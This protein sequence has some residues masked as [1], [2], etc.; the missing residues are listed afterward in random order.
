M[1]LVKV[2]KTLALGTALAV[3]AVGAQAHI[4]G[5]GWTFE[6]NGDVTFD[7]LHWHGDQN[8]TQ[9]QIDAGG[10]GALIVDGVSYDFT[11][12]TN[13][14]TEKTVDGALVNSTYSAYDGDASLTSLVNGTDDWLHVT[15][16]GLSAGAHTINALGC[17]QGWCLTEWELNGSVTT[18]GIV[19]PPVSVSEPGTIA[20]F[21]LGLAGLGFVRRKKA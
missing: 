17:S 19:T 14:D 6:A 16:S 20:L 3:T 9:A 5:L 10:I 2:L 21:G 18:V 7:A 15:I 11:S 1:K 13:D 8:K 4:V 12:Y